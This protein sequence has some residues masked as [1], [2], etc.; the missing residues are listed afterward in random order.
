M[1]NSHTSEERIILCNGKFS[2][3]VFI[4]LKSSKSSSKGKAFSSESSSNLSLCYYLT[5]YRYHHPP[6]ILLIRVCRIVYVYHWNAPG[7]SYLTVRVLFTF[8]QVV[9]LVFTFW[10]WKLSC[11]SLFG[12]GK[13]WDVDVWTR[14]LDDDK[15]CSSVK[16]SSSSSWKEF[17]SL[18]GKQTQQKQKVML[19]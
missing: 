10:S 5:Q 9:A 15:A 3:C 16:E 12:F 6:L 7:T 1:I 8:I 4:W 2:I 13:E 19:F 17:E 11:S 18:R 14:R